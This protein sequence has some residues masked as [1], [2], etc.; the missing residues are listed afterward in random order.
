[1]ARRMAPQSGGLVIPTVQRFR[2]RWLRL[3][4][5]S[6]DARRLAVVLST[7]PG[8]GWQMAHAVGL[9]ALAE[10]FEALAGR[11]VRTARVLMEQPE[12]RGQMLRLPQAE[13][14][15]LITALRSQLDLS[16]SSLLKASPDPP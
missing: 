12:V 10:R 15:S 2:P 14:D 13:L 4:E 6:R 5:T 9:D 1:M 3:A 16:L 7:Y 11:G 8:R